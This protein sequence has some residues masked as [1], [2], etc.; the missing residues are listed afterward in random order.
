MVV[1]FRLNSICELLLSVS[2]IRKQ[3]PN[4]IGNRF[5]ND[6]DAKKYLTVANQ[7][8]WLEDEL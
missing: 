5:V 1:D 2:D 4:R 8:H 6:K 7:A 3:N